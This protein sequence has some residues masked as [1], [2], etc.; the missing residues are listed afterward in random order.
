M[1]DVIRRRVILA[2]TLICGAS[3]VG[4]PCREHGRVEPRALFVQSI[5]GAAIG[6]FLY[7]GAKHDGDRLRH[8][9]FLV[10]VIS[11]CTRLRDVVEYVSLFTLGTA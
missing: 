8:I 5:D 6:P 11:F 10:G 2:A 7:L 9:L 3:R 4:Q 1:P